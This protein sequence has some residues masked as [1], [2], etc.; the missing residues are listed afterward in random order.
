MSDSI[1]FRMDF[2]RKIVYFDEKSRTTIEVVEPDPRRYEW[3]EIDGKRYLYDKFD[4][5]C[6]AEQDYREFVRQIIGIPIYSQPQ[7]IDD[8]KAYVKSRQPLIASMLQGFEHPPTFQDKSEEFLQSLEVNKL[9]F[10]IISLDVVGSTKRATATDSEIYARLIST[11]LYEL[12]EIVPKFHGHVLK[13]TGDGL[14]AYFPEPSF[15]TKNDLAIDCALTLR[16]LV[17]RAL[18]PILEEQGFP[19]IGV[20]IGIDAGEAYIKT[21]GSPETKQ[22]KDIIGAVVNLAAKIQV[23]AKP[24]EIYLGDTVERNLHTMWR[25]ICEPVDLGKDWD[26]KESNG[27]VYR[28]HRVKTGQ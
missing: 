13:Y 10:V 2:V 27:N 20:R 24:G 1:R 28:V 22:Q 7:K 18:N 12:S 6:F 5:T 19:A 17:Y 9:A 23:R 4:N 15:I 16:G 14:I 8:A 11:V 21:I 26:Y 25:Q 3:K